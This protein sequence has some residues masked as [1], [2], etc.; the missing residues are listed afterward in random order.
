[1]FNHFQTV[2][3]QVVSDMT[4][5]CDFLK[6]VEH[7]VHSKCSEQSLTSRLN[8]ALNIVASLASLV[9]IYS[10]IL[11]HSQKSQVQQQLNEYPRQI[12]LSGGEA[13]RGREGTESLVH[14]NG[15]FK[16]GW[17][18][19][20]SSPGLQA[21]PGWKT[22]WCSA[23]AVITVYLNQFFFFALFVICTI[24][25]NTPIASSLSFFFFFA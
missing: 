24:D 25:L 10:L 15:H 11:I 4:N 21:H 13:R 17:V 3:N 18:G 7:K 1:M 14:L 9:L 20:M 8:C 22:L 19:F 23:D 16:H 6:H 12:Q 5:F 2:F